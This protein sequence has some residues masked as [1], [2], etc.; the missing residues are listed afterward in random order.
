M[1]FV[2]PGVGM[3]PVVPSNDETHRENC[4][5]LD[6]GNEILIL[7]F[8]LEPGRIEIEEAVKF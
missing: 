6:S 4:E 3:R 1:G 8:L 2:C 7:T 5:G